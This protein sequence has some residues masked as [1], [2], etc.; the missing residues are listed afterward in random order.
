MFLKISTSELQQ[1]NYYFGLKR[2]LDI[3]NDF[4][5][6]NN[7]VCYWIKDRDDLIFKK[8]GNTSMYFKR[9]TAT[10]REQKITEE[11]GTKF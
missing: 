5:I 6:E 7:Q 9:P 10:D 3:Q 4:S 11:S 1:F 2:Q 8:D